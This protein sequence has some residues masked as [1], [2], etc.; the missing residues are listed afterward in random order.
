MAFFMGNFPLSIVKIEIAWYN[1]TSDF[2]R[3]L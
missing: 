2:I 1:T 3:E